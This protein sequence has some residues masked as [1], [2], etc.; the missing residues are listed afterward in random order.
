V[1]PT[2][3]LKLD[4]SLGWVRYSMPNPKPVVGVV[5]A[6]LTDSFKVQKISIFN[7]LLLDQGPIL[8]SFLPP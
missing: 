7:D 3:A 6:R 1:L 5:E 8:Q 4:L 2:L